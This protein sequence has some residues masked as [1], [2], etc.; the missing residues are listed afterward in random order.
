MVIQWSHPYFLDIVVA[1]W[2][3][4]RYQ[5]F[6]LAFYVAMEN[7]SFDTHDSEEYELVGGELIK[8]EVEQ[9]E[10]DRLDLDEPGIGKLELD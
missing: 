3:H 5:T 8:Q 7:L 9:P 2:Y 1:Q 4:F 10:V 6:I